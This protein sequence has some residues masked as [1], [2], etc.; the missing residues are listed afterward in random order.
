MNRLSLQDRARVLTAL[1]EGNSIRSTV[2]MTGVA[3]N[4]VTKL[5]VEF[6]SACGGYHNVHVRNLKSQ[7]IQC[8]EIWSFVGAKA[9]NVPEEKKGEWGDCWTWT[10]IDAD[11]KLMVSWL[12]GQRTQAC[13]YDFMH[14]VAARLAHRVQLTT[15]G[16]RMYLYAADFAFGT[17]VDYAILQKRYGTPGHNERGSRYS[18]GKYLGCTRACV[19]GT[20]DERHISTSFVER[21]NLNMRMGMR[22][23]TRLTN[24]FSKKLE[25]HGAAVTIY[26]MYYNFC[27][28]HQ[29]LR[30][31]P[32]MEAGLTDH[33]WSVEEMLTAV[34][35]VPSQAE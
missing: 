4:T 16:N 19:S 23:F 13:A 22:R 14:D 30:V 10:A 18:P 9:K 6:G 25:N 2:R 3:K 27:R 11:S 12:V 34:E 5:V 7:R 24:G 29:T 1:V 17:E 35:T 21:Q 8:D 32:A 26:F 20:P 31:T 28:V 33:V 15:D